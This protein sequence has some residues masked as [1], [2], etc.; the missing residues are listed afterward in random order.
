MLPRRYIYST[1]VGIHNSCAG[2]FRKTH[3]KVKQQADLQTKEAA[4]TPREILQEDPLYKIHSNHGKLRGGHWSPFC[5]PYLSVALKHKTT[6]CTAHVL[7]CKVP[8]RHAVPGS[9]MTPARGNLLLDLF[10]KTNFQARQQADLQTKE[11]DLHPEI[12]GPGIPN[13]M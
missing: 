6:L 10:R 7:E 3:F 8:I 11:A 13:Y 9:W 12:Y 4:D 1:C 2:V 5:T